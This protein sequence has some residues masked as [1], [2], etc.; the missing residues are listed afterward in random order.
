MCLTFQVPFSQKKCLQDVTSSP[1]GL[2]NDM[3]ERRSYI[4][5][6]ALTPGLSTNQVLH[7]L[8]PDVIP[9]ATPVLEGIDVEGRYVLIVLK[10]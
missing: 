6:I 2:S 3:P 1:L 7:I 10:I 9:G 8:G 5:T 4:R